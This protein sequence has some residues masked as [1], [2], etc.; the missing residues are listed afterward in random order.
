MKK[1]FTII[2]LL[3]FVSS[4]SSA[5]SKMALG[6]NVGIALP[7][8]DFGDAFKTGF[9]ANAVFLYN[10]NE[11]I[12]LTGS[13]GYFT[14]T[15]KASDDL[16][17]SSIPIL[18]GARYN[19]S[20]MSSLLPYGVVELGFHS[21]TAKAKVFGT[22]VSASETDFGFGLGAGFYY[23]INEKAKIDVN[24]KYNVISADGGSDGYLSIC[25]GVLFSL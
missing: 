2:I 23:P 8:G 22:T 13:L 5:Q 25:A 9:G 17:F 11:N 10:F 12:D 15:S 18:V 24:A 4:Y 21:V 19:L 20:Q 14:W 3:L 7:M 16:T 1:L 6:G